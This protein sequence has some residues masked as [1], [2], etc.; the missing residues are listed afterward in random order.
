MWLPLDQTVPIHEE[1]VYSRLTFTRDVGP[2][3]YW[4]GPI[5][6]PPLRLNDEDGSFLESLLQ[7]QKR[8]PH[9]FH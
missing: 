8:E 1:H 2:G 5:R 9:S 3:G 6:R 4:Q 7:Q